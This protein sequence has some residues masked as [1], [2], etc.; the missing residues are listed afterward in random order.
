MTE[1]C[2]EF[3][4]EMP[5]TPGNREALA[6]PPRKARRACGHRQSL[7]ITSNDVL[8]EE[9]PSRVRT[10]NVTIN[11]NYFAAAR[12]FFTWAV[13]NQIVTR[14]RGRREGQ[15]PRVKENGKALLSVE[16]AEAILPRA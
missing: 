2:D 14:T 1:H 16:E 13:D 6:A 8:L 7:E 9:R 4:K 3:V 15:G 11:D 12:S 5:A 10:K